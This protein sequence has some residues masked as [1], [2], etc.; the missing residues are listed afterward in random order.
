MLTEQSGKIKISKNGE[1]KT[2]HVEFEL[3]K[4][5][6]LISTIAD[7][8]QG[9]GILFDFL[10]LSYLGKYNNKQKVLFFAPWWFLFIIIIFGH[11]AA[12]G[13]SLIRDLSHVPCSIYPMYQGFLTLGPPGKSSKDF[14]NSYLL[15]SLIIQKVPTKA[16]RDSYLHT[17]KTLGP[18][19][20]NFGD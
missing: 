4:K 9:F 10:L 13:S 16:D 8:R 7:K 18:S 6:T 19:L 14:Q 20:S 1:N 11:T 17:D 5:K 12:C 2:S 15:L 3:Q